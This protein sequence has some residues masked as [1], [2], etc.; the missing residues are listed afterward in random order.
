VIHTVG[1][2]THEHDGICVL[3]WVAFCQLILRFADAT[4]YMACVAVCVTA[5]R[6]TA[7]INASKFEELFHFVRKKNHLKCRS[8][9]DYM[10][11]NGGEYSSNQRTVSQPRNAPT[12]LCDCCR[13]HRLIDS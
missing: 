7:T 9:G 12:I 5:T 4:G 8:T 13:I 11:L 10:T 2:K 3:F 6:N 1:W